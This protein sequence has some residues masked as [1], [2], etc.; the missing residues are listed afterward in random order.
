MSTARM[1]VALPIVL[2]AAILFVLLG[3]LLFLGDTIS[4]KPLSR[5]LIG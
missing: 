3:G 1:L 4:G 2:A 5:E